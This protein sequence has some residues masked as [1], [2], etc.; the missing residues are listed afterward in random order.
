MSDQQSPEWFAERLGCVSSSSIADVLAK[1]IKGNKEA[2]T[3]RNLKARLVCEILTGH[4]EE[5]FISWD[6]RRG[7]ELEP[8]A[9]TEYELRRGVDTESVGFVPHPAI[10]RAGASP[11]RLIGANGL[12]EAKCPKTAN[13]LDYLKDGIVPVEYRKQML[14]EMACTGRTWADFLSY[15]PACPDHL[16]VFI[17]RL[18]RDDVLI[19]EIESEVIRFNVEVDE[20]LAALPKPDET[21]HLEEQL[22][23]SIAQAKSADG[24]LEIT[25]EDVPF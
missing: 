19:A 15:N 4:R 20:L 22:V 8:F 6:M 7:L 5:E 14:W 10:Q 25:D 23:A 2:T 21:A 16:Q 18:K 3:R 11:D 24:S 12:L 1:P 17:A 9:V 13:H